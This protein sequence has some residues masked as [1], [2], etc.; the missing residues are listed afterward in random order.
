MKKE[1]EKK[2]KPEVKL[3]LKVKGASPEAVKGAVKK[4]VK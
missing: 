1:S 2:Q 4:I 3:K